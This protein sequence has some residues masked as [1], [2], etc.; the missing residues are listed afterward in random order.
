MPPG[1]VTLCETPPNGSPGYIARRIA[2]V[3]SHIDSRLR[4]LYA[5]PFVA[6]IDEIVLGWITDIVT[7]DA[8]DKRGR[9]PQDAAMQAVEKKR[10]QA[11]AE[12][13]EAANSK[14]GLFDLP[15]R[16]DLQTSAISSGGPLA[17]AEQSPYTWADAQ[18]CVGREEDSNGR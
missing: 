9:N 2:I 16:E 6:P 15:L 4:K 3:Q 10:D 12:I 5:I 1:D 18:A 17:Y 11:F 13:K 8:Y 7:Y 14:D